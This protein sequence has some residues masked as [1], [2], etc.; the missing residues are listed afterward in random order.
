MP[1]SV[2]LST[3]PLARSLQ[4]PESGLR[5]MFVDEWEREADWELETGNDPGVEVNEQQLAYLIYTSGS[6]GQPK[7]VAIEHGSA[8]SLIH[9]A[10][11]IFDQQGLR[12][13][14]F[15]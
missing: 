10:G 14:L 11:E 9:W 7:G 12:G 13:V 6:T 5:L 3:R 2:L 1:V 4:L 15:S 8:T